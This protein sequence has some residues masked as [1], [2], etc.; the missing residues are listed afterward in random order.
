[1]YFLSFF[2]LYFMT[3]LS[4]PYSVP[5]FFGQTIFEMQR[6]WFRE[7]NLFCW[8]CFCVL[9]LLLLRYLFGRCR[10]VTRIHTHSCSLVWMRGGCVYG[11]YAVS[12]F[13]LFFFVFD[14]CR[15]IFNKLMTEMNSYIH[16]S[17]E[18]KTLAKC[19]FFVV[20]RILFISFKTITNDHEHSKI[21]SPYT[22][23]FAFILIIKIFR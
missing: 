18:S 23:S 2:S 9:L 15:V 3:A 5:R 6:G 10:P 22:H 17:F 7:Y 16:S 8:C 11:L 20:G 12:F 21:W 19:Y 4:I 14:V 1:M 13:F